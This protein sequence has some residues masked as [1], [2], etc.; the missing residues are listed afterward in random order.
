MAWEVE[1]TE[2]F[3]AWWETL[4]DDQ[5]DD[6]AHGVGLLTE[7]GP[8]LGFPDVAVLA[9][10]A[11]R[12]HGHPRPAAA[13]GAHPAR[14]NDPAAVP[15]ADRLYDQHLDELKKEGKLNAHSQVS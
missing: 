6:V 7:L 14:A 4:T 5:Q 10:L 8:A 12:P 15:L 3:G 13:V 2:E 9:R 1:F 11:D